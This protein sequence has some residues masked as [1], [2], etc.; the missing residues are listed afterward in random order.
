MS[1][2]EDY[3]YSLPV[4]YLVWIGVV[5]LLYFPCMW[6]AGV[7]SRRRDWWLSYL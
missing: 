6:F 5:I 7:K 4:V 3:G 2:P 1:F